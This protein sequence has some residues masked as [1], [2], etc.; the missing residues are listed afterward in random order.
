MKYENYETDVNESAIFGIKLITIIFLFIF[1]AFLIFK[2]GNNYN[3][4]YLKENYN[5]TKEDR[6]YILD[7][8]Y[9]FILFTKYSIPI[10]VLKKYNGIEV[11]E[12]YKIKMKEEKKIQKKNMEDTARK[13]VK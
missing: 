3:N 6:E 9:R 11:E 4:K 7:N 10:E 13:F 8:H 12:F 2:T 1:I 5:L